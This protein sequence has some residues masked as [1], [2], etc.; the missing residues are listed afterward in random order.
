MSPN[1]PLLDVTVVT[2]TFN[3]AKLIERALD[4][5]R[6]Q[7]RPPTRIIVVD[8][9]SKDGTPDVVRQWAAKHSQPV[10]VEVLAQNA[11]PAGARNRGIELADTRYV[12]FLDSDDEYV[13]G[14]LERLCAGLDLH[15]EAVM[16]FGDATV[17]TPSG[18]TPHGLFAPRLDVASAALPVGEGRYML[19][20]ATQA[21]LRASIIPTSAT[22]FRR[23]QAMAVGGMPADFRSGEDWLFF[24]RLT[25]QGRF[26]FVRD[27]VALHH[28]HDDNLTSPR[29][30]EFM[31]REKLR[32]L[33][34][35]LGPQGGIALSTEQRTQLQ[36]MLAQQVQHWRHHLSSLGLASYLQGL[37]GPV[38]AATGGVAQHLT[39]AVRPLLRACAASLGLVE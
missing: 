5:I 12:A 2:P 3:R 16:S 8:D 22:C 27:D 30:G 17:V 37:K 7:D 14:S 10:H 20:D 11:G 35:L 34:L 25:Q 36:A 29:A 28:R 19:K 32:G 18:Q 4:S 38:G 1:R 26:V 15:P 13:P 31:A 24:L 9:C 6:C 21:L 23:A 39:T 33:L